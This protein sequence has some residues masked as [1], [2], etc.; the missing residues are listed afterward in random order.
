MTEQYDSHVYEW[1]AQQ[2][3]CEYCDDAAG[4]CDC[5]PPLEVVVYD[6]KDQVVQWSGPIGCYYKGGDSES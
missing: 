4:Y 2:Y 5:L 3:K 1:Y 6:D